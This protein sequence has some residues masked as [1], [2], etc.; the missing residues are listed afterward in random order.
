MTREQLLDLGCDADSISY[1]LKTGRL[2]RVY[3]GV[4]AVRYPRTSPAHRA[5]AAVL[6]CGAQ[7]VLS[8][9]SAAAL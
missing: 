4:Y 7:A 9:S 3:P 8:H 6:A 5:A 1:R 2:H